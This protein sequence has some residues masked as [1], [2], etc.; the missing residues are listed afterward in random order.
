[1]RY[2]LKLRG[3]VAK[4]WSMKDK[5]PPAAQEKAFCIWMELFAL[6]QGERPVPPV[7]RPW[8]HRVDVPH[9]DSV[10]LALSR[11]SVRKLYVEDID[12]AWEEF[13]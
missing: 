3:R 4:L 9:Q 8:T 5:L 6:R 13:T 11:P 1:M 10:C 12:W 7:G 2:R